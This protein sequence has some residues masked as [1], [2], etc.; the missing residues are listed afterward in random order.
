[1]ETASSAAPPG[2]RGSKTPLAT[3]AGGG[4]LM[5]ISSPN[6]STT[7]PTSAV[8]AASR[9][10]KPP[11]SIA[12]T[13]NVASPART[14]QLH[15]GSPK[16]RCSPSA[17]PVNSARSVAIATASACSHSSSTARRGRRSRQTSGRLRP[18]AM[19]SLADSVWTSIAIRLAVSTT[20]PRV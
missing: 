1:M 5:K 18:V 13:A 3:A 15:I 12:R 9:R 4:V 16:T 8:I 7:T 17:A 20:Q 14:A 19:P 2:N 6:A 11:T 10:R